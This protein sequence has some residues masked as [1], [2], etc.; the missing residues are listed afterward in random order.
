MVRDAA[1][2]GRGFFEFAETGSGFAG[3]EDAALRVGYA[4]D[5][6]AGECGDAREALEKVQ[7]D[8]LAFEESVGF[9]PDGGDGGVRGQYSSIFVVEFEI[10]D[11]SA[12]VIDF[13][14][15]GRSG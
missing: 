6:R 11:A 4:F 10:G 14:E 7:G 13:F 12:R 15:N 2:V 8:A 9:A 3:I 1:R 5:V